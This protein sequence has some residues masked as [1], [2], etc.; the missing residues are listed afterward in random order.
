MSLTLFN[1]V[2]HLMTSTTKYGIIGTAI[3]GA[4]CLSPVSLYY[5]YLLW[6]L[7]GR[8]VFFQKRRPGMVAIIVILF[9]VYAVVIRPLSDLL[10]L[11]DIGHI[12]GVINIA[13]LL[14]KLSLFAVPIL[15]IRIWL[16]FYEMKHRLYELNSQWKTQLTGSNDQSGWTFKYQWMGNLNILWIIALIFGFMLL[17]IS[18][19]VQ[20]VYYVHFCRFTSP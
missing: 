1:A 19:L 17:S 2:G 20:N 13:T 16:I 10:A 18:M 11:N 5:A 8:H 4:V 12:H 14:S 15:S 7:R 3:L 9:N 6:S